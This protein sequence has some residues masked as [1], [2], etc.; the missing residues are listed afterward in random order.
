[1]NPATGNRKSCGNPGGTSDGG[2]TGTFCNN[3]N[4]PFT[5]LGGMFTCCRCHRAKTWLEIVRIVNIPV[6]ITAR[7][8]GGLD[9]LRKRAKHCEVV[10][11]RT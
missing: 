3:A 1:M 2:F 5:R 4:C 11:L 8:D 7:R 10:L 6:A 9:L